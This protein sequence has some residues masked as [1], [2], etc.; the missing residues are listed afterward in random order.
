VAAPAHLLVSLACRI[1]RI[2][3][4]LFLG[5]DRR[6]AFDLFGGEE[7]C[8]L[9]GFEPGPR[10]AFGSPDCFFRQFSL[11]LESSSA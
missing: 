4:R 3:L 7:S 8:R 11:A 10:L 9:F 2:T 1:A 6:R 5:R